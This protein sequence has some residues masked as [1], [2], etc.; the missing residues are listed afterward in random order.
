PVAMRLDS[1][2]KAW[3]LRLD[4]APKACR[5]RPRK[6]ALAGEAFR[7]ARHRERPAYAAVEGSRCILHHRDAL[8]RISARMRTS[9]RALI[10]TACAIASLWP[11]WQ[12]L[13][14]TWS[15][16]ADYHHG[17]IVALISLVWLIRACIKLDK[18]DAQ[19][20]VGAALLLGLALCLWLIAF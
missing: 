2:Q 20:I 19:R 3:R 6:L 17:P 4:S 10:A 14:Q 11:T 13:A 12:P 9:Q 8:I 7:E 1:R 16:M 15:D 18:A 5:I